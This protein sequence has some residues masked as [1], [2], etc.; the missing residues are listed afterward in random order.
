MAQVNEFEQIL[1]WVPNGTR[2][3]DLGCGDGT[4]LEL[5]KK[6]NNA[7]GYGLEINS[8]CIAAC[9][10]KG[11]NVIEQNFDLGLNNFADKSFDFTLL[12]ST[13]HAARRPDRLLN[14][15]LR[16]GKNAI[17]TFPNFGNWQHRLYLTLRGR[18]PVSEALPYAWYET[19]NIHLCTIRDFSHLCRQKKI[20]IKDKTVK[21][22]GPA[23]SLFPNFWGQ[24]AMF[25]LGK[26]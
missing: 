3:L 26:S 15:M 12:T 19:P 14:E 5:L 10:G 2:V 21:G 1:S 20:L 11:V 6:R 25:L 8:N 4:L 16:I 9:L 7:R 18:M 13:L 17:V 24:E 23:G 22:G